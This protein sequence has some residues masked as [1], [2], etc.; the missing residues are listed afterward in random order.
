MLDWSGLWLDGGRSRRATCMDW[1]SSS[2]SLRGHTK[3]YTFKNLSKVKASGSILS[4]CWTHKSQPKKSMMW[5]HPRRPTAGEGARI[6]LPFRRAARTRPATGT[7]LS[8]SC[9]RRRSWGWSWRPL[10]YP[11]S[12][13]TWSSSICR[14]IQTRF[15]NQP[16]VSFISFRWETWINQPILPHGTRGIG[17]RILI[18]FQIHRWT[19][20]A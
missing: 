11:L 20:T 7:R 12:T 13:R 2:M 16:L 9:R 18:H 8:R 1:K 5:Q 17:S 4:L 3:L 14:K 19:N 6:P 15:I 10:C